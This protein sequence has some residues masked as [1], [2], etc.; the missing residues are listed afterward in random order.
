MQMHDQTMYG[1]RAHLSVK[2]SKKKTRR[3]KSSRVERG[4]L[5][6]TSPP[7][8]V[9]NVALAVARTITA[10]G[11]KPI[12]NYIAVSGANRN[13]DQIECYCDDINENK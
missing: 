10:H 11:A 2:H 1:S 7:P 4:Y 5:L 13:K 12:Y 8:F 3:N 6:P 9:S